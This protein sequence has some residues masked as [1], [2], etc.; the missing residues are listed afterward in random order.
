MRLRLAGRN[1]L[2]LIATALAML[3]KETAITWI[4]ALVI[5]DWL[6]GRRPF[7]IGR[8]LATYG[9]L[10]LMWALI[11]PALGRLL[12][13]G[14]RAGTTGYVGLEHP[15]RWAPYFGKYLLTI[16]NIPAAR[17]AFMAPAGCL[18]RGGAPLE[19]R[20]PLAILAGPPATAP[21][22]VN[23]APSRVVLLATLLALPSLL[24]TATMLRFWIPYYATI[25]G[26]GSSLLLGLGLSRI[27]LPWAAVA[28]AAFFELGMVSR[29]RVAPGTTTSSTSLSSGM[30]RE[31]RRVQAPS[32]TR[33]MRRYWCQ[34]RRD[35]P[36]G[37]YAHM[38]SIQALKVWY[39]DPRS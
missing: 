14:L 19:P 39:R 13:H 6:I 5:L 12:G 3:S 32:H 22:A 2:A 26:V 17:V 24:I 36:A 29:W 28:L 10:V 27:L 18:T 38:Y 25:S 4:P 37:A 11:H 33:P 15:E 34:F 8:H 16:I 20:H 23:L 1:A 9:A 7:R 30:P 31:S 21:R 35:R